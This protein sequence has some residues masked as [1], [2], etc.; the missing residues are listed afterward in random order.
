MITLE[1]MSKKGF[2]L[3][4]L[5]IAIAIIGALVSI[6]VVATMTIRQRSRD[7]R[8]K[9]DLNQI[10]RMMSSS[11]CFIPAS[12]G[13]GDYDLGDIFTEFKNRQIAQT[14]PYME[15]APRDPLAGEG[16]A[17]RYRYIVTVDGTACAVYANLENTGDPVTLTSLTAPT[18]GVGIGVLRGTAIGVNGTK[19]YYQISNR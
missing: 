2:T 1:I 7:S 14:L 18:P 6:S 8:R 17:T 10:N 5:L 16:V 12:Y 15:V 4:E 9:Y 13:T 19:M 3:I 11:I